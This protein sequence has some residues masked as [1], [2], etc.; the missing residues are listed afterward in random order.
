MRGVERKRAN[1]YQV[2]GG[3]QCTKSPGFETSIQVGTNGVCSLSRVCFFFLFLSLSLLASIRR[4]LGW[5][6]RCSCVRVCAVRESVCN[7]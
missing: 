6:V 1:R 7:Y 3:K 4:C 2:R 5:C